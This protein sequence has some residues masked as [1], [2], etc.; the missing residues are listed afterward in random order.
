MLSYDTQ[1]NIALNLSYPDI[2][3]G[4]TNKALIKILNDNNFSDKI[5]YE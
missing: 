5:Y 4:N 3:F 1:L 2:A